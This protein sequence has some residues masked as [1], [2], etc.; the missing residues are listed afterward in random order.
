MSPRIPRL[1]RALG[2]LGTLALA[3]GAALCVA[4]L[5][6]FLRAVAHAFLP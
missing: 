2:L 4:S 1:R 6:G 5:L 3:F